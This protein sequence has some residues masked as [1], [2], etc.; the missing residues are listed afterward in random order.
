MHN[1]IIIFIL[2]WGAAL[3]FPNSLNAWDNKSTHLQISQK[4]S[5]ISVLNAGFLLSLRLE[6]NDASKF[7]VDGTL[8]YNKPISSW[9]LDGANFEDAGNI[10]TGRFYNHFHNPLKSSLEAGLDDFF[11]FVPVTGESALL[12]AQDAHPAGGNSEWSWQTVRDYFYYGLTAL[13]LSDREIYLAKTFEGLGHQIHLIQDM[14]QPAHVRNDAHPIDGLGWWVAGLESWAKNNPATINDYTNINNIL[15]VGPQSSPSFKPITQFFDTDQYDGTGFTLPSGFGNFGLSEYTN[16]NYF[17]D[18][19]INSPFD[20]HHF[21]Y[22]LIPLN[23]CED[24]APSNSLATTQ[25][26]ASRNPCD[27]NPI[28]HFLAVDVLDDPNN[29]YLYTLDPRVHEDYAKDL[30]PRAVGYSAAMIDYFFRGQLQIVPIDDTQ[31]KIRNFSQEPLND[32]IIEIYYDNGSNQRL[33]LI[34]PY[35]VS[36]P[37]GPGE[38]TAAIELSPPPDNKSPNRYWAI[39]RGTLGAESDAVIGSFG[40]WWIEE[41]NRDLEDGHSWYATINDPLL[42]RTAPGGA[43]QSEVQDGTLVMTNSVPAGTQWGPLPLDPNLTDG[44]QTNEVFIGISPHSFPSELDNFPDLFPIPVQPETELRMKVDAFDINEIPSGPICPELPTEQSSDAFQIISVDLTDG[45]ILQ[46]TR[47]GQEASLPNNIIY[48]IP[49]GEDVVVN[50]Y[51]VL[52]ANG[53]SITP[54]LG[55]KNISVI[56]QFFAPS[57]E[58][59]FS[60]VEQNIQ[61]DYIRVVE[62]VG[63]P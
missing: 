32:G 44:N 6:N 21:T 25:V 15:P 57:C 37:I 14:S 19:T 55:I 33:P 11:F 16:A 62:N 23:L 1:Q 35:S 36:S 61:V 2:S 60:P 41:W 39:F 58:P 53:I 46:F 51:S 30:I 18:D 43:I 4:A 42:N 24:D 45:T 47:P 56:Q 8:I 40:L 7:D 52:Q 27:T 3:A 50:I 31:F 9:I 10:F 5:E 20:R 63:A 13:N 17:S 34:S 28:D 48:N 59:S 26:Y 38:S 29:H 12:W 49:I 22:P 54:S